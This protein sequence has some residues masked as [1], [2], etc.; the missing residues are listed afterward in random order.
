MDRINSAAIAA[1]A[2]S[3]VPMSALAVDPVFL[4]S[5]GTNLFRATNGT[6]ETYATSIEMLSMFYDSSL[7]A[8]LVGTR[9]VPGNVPLYQ[10][11]NALAG[12][13]TFTQFATLDRFY[14]T[15]TRIGS[16]YY[17]FSEGT[18]YSIDLQDPQNP[19][20]TMI[21]TTGLT[22][23]GGSAYDPVSG[24]YYLIARENDGLYS[25]NWNTAQLTFI[26]TVQDDLGGTGLEWWEGG[27]YVAAQ[28]FSSGDFEIGR[29]DTSNAH[30]SLIHAL[31]A[32][33]MPQST[34]LAIIPEPASWIAMI[35]FG[36]LGL[37]GRRH[38]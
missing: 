16:Q 29:V 28:N 12:V 5:Q 20:E 8:V 17:G 3:A 4:A 18:L 22:T 15:L 9:G 27:L 21:G 1:C 7:D 26:G 36:H 31:G 13:P 10:M 37:R 30:Y 23:S 25:V 24:T 38:G 2:I 32:P 11:G 14:G 6:I 19:I 34:S 33:A 35:I